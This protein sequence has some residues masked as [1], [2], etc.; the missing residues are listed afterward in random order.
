[1][2]TIR[3]LPTRPSPVGK[4]KSPRR[5]TPTLILAEPESAGVV[6]PFESLE[7]R[8]R[9][10]LKTAH[11]D[12]ERILKD[13]ER[14]L[15]AYT[16]QKSAEP[17][18]RELLEMRGRLQKKIRDTFVNLAK[19]TELTREEDR[20]LELLSRLISQLVQFLSVDFY[21]DVLQSLANFGK[22]DEY[23]EFGLDHTLIK[24]IKP[25]FDFLYYKYWR[26]EVK[27]INHIPSKGPALL[28]ANHSGTLPYDGAMIKAA[29]LNEHLE[30]QDA[31]FLVE[32]FVYHFPFLGTLMYRI[33]GVRA[34]PENAER[35]LREG[36]LVIVFPEGVKG[37]GKLFKERY[38]LQ[39]FGRGGFIRLAL[40]TGA[41]IIPVAVIGAEEIHP[42]L[43]K[44]NILAKPLGI[45][46]VPITPTMPWL[47]PLGLIPLPSKWSIHF[48]EP[49]HLKP[50]DEHAT[51]EDLYVH[52]TSEEV[53]SKIQD[54]ISDNLRKRQ[55]V[56]WG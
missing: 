34:S 4:K 45:P 12:I 2:A 47:G 49:I 50:L 42:L 43:Y 14:D 17:L 44:S 7:E 53:R 18:S 55:S 51:D 25:L 48:G 21:R 46:Y 33:G 31:R 16:P 13:I 37:I 15:S 27:G 54:M 5:E 22:Q 36:H 23:D 6:P 11:Y 32:D 30:R 24:R 39:R 3:R 29:V 41:P 1:M 20:N 8:L 38:Q 35:L 26:V 40:R 9:E 10:R 52:Q 19:R 56:W 28:V